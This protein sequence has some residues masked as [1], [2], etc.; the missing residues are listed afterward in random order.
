M[1]LKTIKQPLIYSLLVITLIAIPLVSSAKNNKPFIQFTQTE[2]QQFKGYYSTKFGYLFIKAHKQFASTTV[3][4]KFIRL[5]KKADGRIYPQYRF[6]GLFPIKLTNLSF[7]LV[8]HKGKRQVMMHSKKH[9]PKTVGQQFQT[10]P[11]PNN[12]LKRLD[13]YK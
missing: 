8:T 13:R 9:R 1:I 5:V 3:D 2:L 12:W 10:N 11:I 6:L 7:S 4:G